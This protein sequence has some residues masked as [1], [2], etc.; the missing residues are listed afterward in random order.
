MKLFENEKKMQEWLEC[1]LKNREGLGDL[2]DGIDTVPKSI[3]S[4]SSEKINGVYHYCLRALHMLEVIAAN[5]NIALGKKDSLKPDILAYAPETQSIVII[6]LKNISGPTREAGT[7]LS[8]YCAEIN[9]YLPF[10]SDADIVNIIISNEWPTLLRKHAVQDILWRG[11]KLLCLRPYR[12]QSEIR[13]KAVPPEELGCAEV[14]LKLN[15]Q[16]L[17]G[18]QLCLYDYGR[19]SD[20]LDQNLPQMRTALSAMAAKGNLAGNHGFAFLWKDLWKDS[21]APYSI[22]ILNVAAFNQLDRFLIDLHEGEELSGMKDRFLRLVADYSPEG[23][24]WSLVELTREAERFLKGFCSPKP[25]GFTTWPGLFKV[26][27]DRAEHVS[28]AAWGFWG[29]RHLEMLQ[30]EYNSGQTPFFDSPEFGLRLV[31]DVIDDSVPYIDLSLYA[32]DGSEDSI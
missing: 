13:L 7:E 8:A 16:H 1:E 18:Y 28:F 20:R 14:D 17:G 31:S 21:C 5:E 19:G 29:E 6:E 12:N 26:M 11:R 4:R 2:I 3:S 32:W 23:H 30:K 25:E 9:N 15:P 10:I 24:S 22:T 27:S